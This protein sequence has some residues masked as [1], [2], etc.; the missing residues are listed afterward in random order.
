MYLCLVVTACPE[1]SRMGGRRRLSRR[2]LHSVM[3]DAQFDASLSS[4]GAELGGD[5]AFVSV[6][7]IE[8]RSDVQR[9]DKPA[10]GRCAR[11]LR[12]LRRRFRPSNNSFATK[13][14]S[15]RSQPGAA[16]CLSSNDVPRSAPDR[17]FIDV[18]TSSITLSDVSTHLRQ[19]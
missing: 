13:L 6:T 8:W 18:T 11:P 17:G 2:Q 1:R 19:G 15:R 3:G 4:D 5:F 9:R 16:G 14:N 10:G 12:F 7:A